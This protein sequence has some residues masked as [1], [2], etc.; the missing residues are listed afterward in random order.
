MTVPIQFS[1]GVWIC[2]SFFQHTVEDQTVVLLS[3]MKKIKQ[4]I[5]DLAS[6]KQVITSFSFLCRD[7]KSYKYC[8][9]SNV[10]LSL[11][12]YCYMIMQNSSTMLPHI[13]TPGTS[14]PCFIILW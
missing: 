6:A 8:P 7:H 5:A 1:C 11:V 2:Q 4:D 3:E 10:A 12:E 14:N 13:I 9:M